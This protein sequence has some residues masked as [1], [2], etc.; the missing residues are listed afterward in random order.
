MINIILCLFLDASLKKREVL[1]CWMH[2]Y[3]LIQQYK[4]HGF[5][6]VEV[7]HNTIYQ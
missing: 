2:V 4:S 3:Q 7:F 6:T 5:H 1:V